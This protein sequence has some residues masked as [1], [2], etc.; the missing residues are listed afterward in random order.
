MK[1]RLL[2]LLILLGSFNAQA[3]KVK[4]YYVTQKNDTVEVTFNAPFRLSGLNLIKI[5]NE[6]FYYTNI[7]NGEVAK[8]IPKDVIYINMSV[9]EDYQ[10]HIVPFNNSFVERIVEGRL[11]Y[12]KSEY[13]GTYQTRSVLFPESKAR[14]VVYYL[15]LKGGERRQIEGS[16]GLVKKGFWQDFLGKDYPEFVS[17]LTWDRATRKQMLKKGK[18]CVLK[19][20]TFKNVIALFNQTYK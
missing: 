3:K 10:Y 13:M 20:A 4:G 8:I 19:E 9:D 18:T 14:T 15:E 11:S 5:S 6:I 17:C 16:Y 12:Y 7:K 1:C 2:F